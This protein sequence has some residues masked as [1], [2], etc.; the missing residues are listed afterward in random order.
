[1]PVKNKIIAG[2][3]GPE[4]KPFSRNGTRLDWAIEKSQQVDHWRAQLGEKFGKRLGQTGG[5]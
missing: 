5:N 1:M 2:S 3:I 4:W